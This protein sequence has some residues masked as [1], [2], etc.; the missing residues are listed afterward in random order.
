MLGSTS[1]RSKVDLFHASLSVITMVPF[2]HS[3]S[4][5]GVSFSSGLLYLVPPLILTSCL[6]S[7]CVSPLKLIF[8][9]GTTSPSLVKIKTS[10]DK[11]KST[12]LQC[13]NPLDNYKNMFSNQ[14]QSTT[15]PLPPTSRASRN[16]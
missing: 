6:A 8:I 9:L 2:F 16:C 5:N 3:R 10:K 1:H 11:S 12:L 4:N 7:P 14:F 15:N 13:F